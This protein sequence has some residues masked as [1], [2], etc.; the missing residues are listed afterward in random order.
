MLSLT[1]LPA[2]LYS[3]AGIA[4]EYALRWVYPI[5]LA[6]VAAGCVAAG[7][8]YC[9]PG[10][11]VLSLT[12]V[13][14]GTTSFARQI[15]AIGRQE[16]AFLLFT[17]I[18][19]AVT[20]NEIDIKRRRLLAVISGIGLG[21]AHYTTS[22]V[23]GFM[24]LL[25]IIITPILT[26]K[27]VG[28]QRVLSLGVCLGIIGS[29]VLWNG[30]ITR[31][32][33]ELNDA[34]VIISDTGL[35]FLDN[36]SKNPLI[37]WIRGTGPQ[38]TTYENYS[39]QIIE[40]R[41]ELGW[42]K[43]DPLASKY[44][45]TNSVSPT[46]QGAVPFLKGPW[47]LLNLITK[48]I[49]IIV[50]IISLLWYFRRVLKGEKETNVEL[51]VLGAGA[52]LI[53]AILRVSSTAGLLYNPERAAI[54]AGLVFSIIIAIFLSRIKIKKYIPTVLATIV[55]ISSW[56]LAVPAFGGNP[57]ATYS[58]KGEDVE[59]YITTP[60]DGATSNWIATVL[61]KG[62]LVHADRYGR[63]SLLAYETRSNFTIIDV[64]IPNSVHRSGYVLFTSMNTNT[65]R[66]RGQIDTS[67]SIFTSPEPFFKQTRNLVYSTGDTHVYR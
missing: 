15:P 12:L 64:I 43:I 46:M 58:T 65:K 1:V 66:A 16:I 60:A 14:L 23:T 22:Y 41:D 28:K 47:T 45:I 24:L 25:V 21:F 54:H 6:L 2:Q 7:R 35:R 8:K 40:R 18:I 34:T 57:I 30:V 59:R 37:S 55:L 36:D 5:A 10:P 29:T 61:P 53:S 32:A 67:F 62:T 56:G 51:L 9:K 38:L 4:P 63:V 19:L 26:G 42:F 44:K 52:L 27:G 33:S 20:S 13:V 49:I 39:E 3:I 31:P 11:V 17:T 50:I 48:Q